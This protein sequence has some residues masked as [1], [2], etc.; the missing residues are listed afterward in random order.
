ML[1]RRVFFNLNRMTS[2]DEFA[3]TKSFVRSWLP[4]LIAAAALVIYAATLNHWVTVESVGYVSRIGDWDWQPGLFPPA[5]YLVTA[6]FRLLPANVLPIALNLFS[7]VC[8]TLTLA[9]LARSVALLPHDRTHEQREREKNESG[10]LSIRSAWLPPVFAALVCGLQLTFWENAVA[11]SSEM[12]ELL[13]FACVIRC[14]LE[15]RIDLRGSW[16]TKLA[17]VY[18]AGMANNWPM[19]AFLPVLVVALI[20]IKGRAFFDLKFILR[21]AAWGLLGFSLILLLPI[22]FAV[23]GD[24]PWGFW[25]VLK[26]EL[27]TDKMWLV[28]VFRHKALLALLLYSLLPL[29]MIGIRWASSFGDSNPMGATLA[30]FS[31]HLVHG[32]FF[33]IGLWVMLDPQFSPRRFPSQAGFP[34]VPFLKLYY[35]VALCVGYFAGYFLLVFGKAPGRPRPPSFGNVIRPALPIAV[36]VLCVLAP[37]GLIYKNLPQIQLQRASV[38]KDFSEL[39]L[40]SLPQKTAIVLSDD[41]MQLF[42]LKA[43]LNEHRSQDKYIL[44]NTALIHYPDYLRYAQKKYRQD[45]KDVIAPDAKERLSDS[46]AMQVSMALFQRYPV[47]YLHPSFGYYFEQLYARPHGIVYELLPYPPN[48]IAAPP[49]TPELISE[50]NAFWSRAEKRLGAVA[51]ILARP[52][53]P[54]QPGVGRE[55]FRALQLERETDSVAELIGGFYS[56]ALNQWGVEL[57]RSGN[58]SDA[59][60]FFARAQDLNADNAVARI[61]LKFNKNVLAGN[62]EAVPF[63]KSLEDEF[64]KYRS[65]SSV[66]GICGLYDEPNRCFE[67]GQIFARAKP[68][69]QPL[70]AQAAQQFERV[71]MFS[72]TNLPAQFWLLQFYSQ[73]GFPSRALA[74][75]AGLQPQIQSGVVDPN[76][77]LQLGYVEAVAHFKL[78]EPNKGSAA[79]QRVLKSFP[80]D[81]ALLVAATRLYLDAG[82]YSN[83]LD[84]LEQHLKLDPNNTSALVNKGVVCIR[85]KHYET[86]VA[87]L[88]RAITL[89]PTNYVAV[90]NRIGARRSRSGS[91]TTTRRRT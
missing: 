86:A 81:E 71:R 40:E 76:V 26:S 78:N 23:S 89:Q 17:I 25:Q 77:A 30:A 15:Y 45:W 29:A 16:L 53:T 22:I 46:G 42:F 48:S 49:L 88:S 68:P 3:P 35:L 7:A 80:D 21:M 56:R 73:Y 41:P 70:L 47:Y 8:A 61:N 55:F 2:Q 12:F 65:L 14:L 72:P 66:M 60:N 52:K 91:T 57:Q 54:P 27:G 36:C 13:L 18:G 28:A 85:L 90:F 59:G 33:L 37:V 11:A 9:L 32:A 63:P 62:N 39:A 34:Q 43:A 67:Q 44:L 6:P 24:S 64:G 1:I 87:S 51:D 20:W 50:N 10:L 4:W 82:N 5:Y 74:I 58:F 83:A 84:V 69:M 75:V 79:L 31:F 19:I 38:I